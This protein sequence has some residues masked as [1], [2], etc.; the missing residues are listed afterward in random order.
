MRKVV[1]IS[2]ILALIA[3]IMVFS[4]YRGDDDASM[5]D[6]IAAGPA[7]LGLILGVIVFPGKLKKLSF[8]LAFSL[9]LNLIAFGMWIVW[10]IFQLV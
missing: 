2:I 5:L 9:L 10:I 1:T 3:G 6:L 4:L 7:V 8:G